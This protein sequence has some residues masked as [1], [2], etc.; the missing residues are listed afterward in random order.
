MENE[1]YHHEHSGHHHH[2]HAEHHDHNGHHHHEHFSG[3]N[4]GKAFAIGVTLNLLFVVAETVAGFFSNSMGL[5]S[6]AGH[7]LSDVVSLLLAWLAFR[8][9]K[10]AANKRYTYGYSKSTVLASLVNACIL[11]VAIG[12]IVSESI[13]KFYHPQPVDGNTVIWI[14]SIGVVIN[15]VTALLFMKGRKHDLNVKGAFLHMM[16]DALVS[17]GVVISGVIIKY[18]GWN[19]V[20]PIVGLLIALVIL[21]STWGLLRQ[22]LRLSLDGVP[23]DIDLENIKHLICNIDGVTGIHHIH[24]W[25][26]GTSETA[27]TTHISVADIGESEKIKSTIKKMLAGQGISHA[28]IETEPKGYS[29]EDCK[30]D[31]EK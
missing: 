2:E 1:N 21:Y 22:S 28:T 12:M 18:T 13:R 29:C 26:I 11:L 8:L 31:C 17:I 16:M 5:L 10:I 24:I 19:L 27:L 15:F 30:C 6:D 25:A 7:N 23:E 4:L 3:E 14:A 20:D 9:T